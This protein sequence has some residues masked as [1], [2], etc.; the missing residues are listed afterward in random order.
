MNV[1]DNTETALEP[2]TGIY[3]GFPDVDA[4]QLSGKFYGFGG[5]CV[6]AGV[7]IGHGNTEGPSPGEETTL[8]EAQAHD[9]TRL[10]GDGQ[11]V[12]NTLKNSSEVAADAGDGG[13]DD[14]G[15]QSG[16]EPVF[17]GRGTF[18]VA[19]ECGDG[20]QHGLSLRM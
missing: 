6:V 8:L 17:N 4:W 15:D 5:G 3:A 18:F 13:D 1:I 11:L 12:G 16:H 19:D 7:E 9:L 14:S 20:G 10:R 2:G